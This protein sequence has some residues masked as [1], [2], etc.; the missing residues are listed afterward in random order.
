MT[1]LNGF[2]EANIIRVQFH[3]FGQISCF[4][5]LINDCKQSHFS[6]P[7]LWISLCVFVRNE[8]VIYESMKPNEILKLRFVAKIENN[9][10]K[11]AFQLFLL[12][13]NYKSWS[14]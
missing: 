6:A 4:F 12:S 8:C 7:I 10:K 5:L 9:S 2:N 14:A 11:A 13:L 3:S 1:K